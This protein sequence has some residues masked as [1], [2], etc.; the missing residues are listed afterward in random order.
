MYGSPVIAEYIQTKYITKLPSA[1]LATG[2]VIL[3]IVIA[4][5]GT[6]LDTIVKQ[7]KEDFEHELLRYQDFNKK[8]GEK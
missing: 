7:H 3:G 6:V 4:Q 1:V 2:F 8:E 5:C